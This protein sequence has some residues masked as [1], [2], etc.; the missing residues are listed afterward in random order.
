MDL[1]LIP[2][3]QCYQVFCNK[4][5]LL[6]VDSNLDIVMDHV[7]PPGNIIGS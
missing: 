7:S 6:R 5:M 4:T 2:I 3:R 1:G